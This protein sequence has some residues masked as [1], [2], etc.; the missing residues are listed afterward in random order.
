MNP[1]ESVNRVYAFVSNPEGGELVSDMESED[2][3]V[4][5]FKAT[6]ETRKPNGN[7][8]NLR[9]FYLHYEGKIYMEKD[10][11]KINT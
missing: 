6:I 5:K 9:S 4:K 8:Y 11:E 2:R 7:W 3:E 1:Y 10:F